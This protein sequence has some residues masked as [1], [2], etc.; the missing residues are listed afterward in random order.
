MAAL[1]E[2]FCAACGTKSECRQPDGVRPDPGRNTD[3]SFSQ[4]P[5]REQTPERPKKFI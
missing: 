5:M 4:I 1:P 3:V 2:L